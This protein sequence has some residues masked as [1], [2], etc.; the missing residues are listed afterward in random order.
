[1]SGKA[2]RNTLAYALNAAACAARKFSVGR[3][4]RPCL[5][6]REGDFVLVDDSG[7]SLVV[8]SPLTP[9]EIE[10]QRAKGSLL[11]DICTTIGVPR[12][13]VE[14]VLSAEEVGGMKG[15]AS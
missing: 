15:G 8:S 11:V 10:C 2:G 12:S 9:V 5:S 14:I 4:N 7:G 6:W 3:V 13:H 1:M